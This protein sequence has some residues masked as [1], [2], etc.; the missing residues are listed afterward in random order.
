MQALSELQQAL[1][2]CSVDEPEDCD[3]EEVA[4]ELKTDELVV[5]AP[6]SSSGGKRRAVKNLLHSLTGGTFKTELSP[7]QVASFLAAP[8]EVEAGL[9]GVSRAD[10]VARLKEDGVE[11]STISNAIV[12]VLPFLP[13]QE[14]PGGASLEAPKK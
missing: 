9:K 14:T 12:N 2:T 7:L 1:E 13:G 6:K 11:D 10:L 5:T 4:E 3:P 8:E